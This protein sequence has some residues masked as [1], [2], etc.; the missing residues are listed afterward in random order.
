MHLTHVSLVYSVLASL[1]PPLLSL[2]GI[3]LIMS[4]LLLSLLTLLPY[5]TTHAVQLSHTHK[6]LTQ[7]HGD[8]MAQTHTLV[9]AQTQAQQHAQAL[10]IPL[11][12]K[13]RTDEEVSDRT[14]GSCCLVCHV[15]FC[16]V[17]S[18][19]VCVMLC[20]VVSCRVMPCHVE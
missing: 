16:H 4:R 3:P 6:H 8:A 18:C 11:Q 1:T 20:R 2:L 7:A 15:M 19:V 17:M 13:A 10:R 9:H 12:H 5:T 14:G